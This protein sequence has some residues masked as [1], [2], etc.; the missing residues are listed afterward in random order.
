MKTFDNN[1]LRRLK[2]HFHIWKQKNFIVF[3]YQY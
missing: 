2:V 1:I 3:I